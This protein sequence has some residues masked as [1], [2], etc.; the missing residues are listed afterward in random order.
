L[1]GGIAALV[2]RAD[3]VAPPPLAFCP[4]PL[5]APLPPP[6]RSPRA[7]RCPSPHPA[8][9]A[10]RFHTPR[11][12]TPTSSGDLQGPHER[13]SIAG[14]SYTYTRGRGADA[15][16]LP[17]AVA[18]PPLAAPVATPPPPASAAKRL[19]SAATAPV[20]AAPSPPPAEGA[21]SAARLGEPC[22]ACAAAMA[23]AL[24]MLIPQSSPHHPASQWQNPN[25]HA[26]RPRHSLGQ[27]LVRG[28]PRVEE[29]QLNTGEGGM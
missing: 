21:R 28:W 13:R 20:A 15:A 4:L 27:S 8:P 24:P 25:A 19:P 10:P 16:A 12:L 22:T 2:W 7:T 5:P 9:P 14:T 11:P 29:R 3:L 18:H 6:P 1:N 23:L 26:P 17:L